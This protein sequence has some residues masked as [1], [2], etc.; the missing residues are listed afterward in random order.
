MTYSIS[1]GFDEITG[2]KIK[3]D[4]IGLCK[5]DISSCVLDYNI[6]PHITLSI[7]EYEPGIMDVLK[8]VVDSS[9]TFIKSD[10]IHFSSIGIFHPPVLYYAPVVTKQLIDINEKVY[11]LLKDI[12]AKFT[13]YY[14]PDNWV[15]HVSLGYNMTNKDLLVAFE[16]INDT[17][18]AFD[19]QYTKLILSKYDPYSEIYVVELER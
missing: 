10:K 4:I 7:F 9:G 19:G 15:P 13:P 1:L 2:D 8:K 11:N 18:N 12:N 16:Y 14:V 17:F 3:Q 6:P 5:K